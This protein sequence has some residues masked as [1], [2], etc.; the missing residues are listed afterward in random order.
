MVRVSSLP[1]T[2][3][4]AP[5]LALAAAALF[6]IS[7]PIAKLLVGNVTPVMMAG[8]L[9][10]GSGT[11]LTALLVLRHIFGKKVEEASL[12]RKDMPWLLG[13]IVFGGVLG[14]ILL[15]WG[16]A[17]TDAASA[18]LLL[19]LEAVATLVIAWLV[20]REHV[21]RKLFM[22]AIAIVLGAVLLSFEGG[23]G[24]GG[25][26]VPLIALACLS[27]GI[28]NNLTRKISAVDPV[29]LAAIKGLAAGAVNLSLAYALG[30]SWP[31]ISSTVAA[32]ALGFV[33]YGLGLVLFIVALRHLGSARTGAYYGTAPFL[34]ALAAAAF[35]GAT[36]TPMILIAGALMAF[37]AWL[38]LSERHTHEH[39]HEELEHEHRHSHDAHHQHAHA[40][41]QQSSE[42]HSHPHRHLAMTHSH[43]HWPDVHHGH[44][45]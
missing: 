21:D 33:S 9:Y 27:W 31:S 36:L 6:G 37:G 19:N 24:K 4:K 14:P 15:M 1:N 10:L 2:D 7:T 11:G 43:R 8:L 13:T 41:G 3:L 29:V 32:M 20:F 34:G 18:S 17:T 12:A 39:A 28:D 23:I 5:L 45:H 38:H 22:G 42:P 44:T 25:W 26:G 40:A 35:L 30:V 16:L